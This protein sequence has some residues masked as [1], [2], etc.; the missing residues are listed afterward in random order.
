MSCGRIWPEPDA[1][2]LVQPVHVG[3]CQPRQA[4]GSI[5]ASK[6][7]PRKQ[8]GWAKAGTPAL[9]TM[10][11]ATPTLPS[12][13]GSEGDSRVLSVLPCPVPPTRVETLVP[14]L[15]QVGSAVWGDHL[16]GHHVPPHLVGGPHRHRRGPLPPALCDLQEARC[17]S[18]AAL[19]VRCPLLALRLLSQPAHQLSQRACLRVC[20]PKG[21]LWSSSLIPPHGVR[22]PQGVC[23]LRAHTTPCQTPRTW[24]CLL[25]SNLRRVAGLLVCVPDQGLPDR[26]AGS[27][28][29]DTG[30]G[31]STLRQ[32][33]IPGDS[34]LRVR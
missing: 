31:V 1:C 34:T 26:K 25:R 15:Q 2:P 24:N 6:P 11:I 4:C 18:Q 16:R 5:S 14:I 33:R 12:C 19:G 32:A 29:L 28:S 21:S 8:D 10:G 23:P 9:G 30:A 3:G 17:V 7:N 22:S 20:A 27:Q 13:A